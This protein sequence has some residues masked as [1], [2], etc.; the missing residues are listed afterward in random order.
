MI[1][2]N[3]IYMSGKFTKKLNMNKSE[4][5]YKNNVWRW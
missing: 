5:N 3:K 1:L 4:K 2:K